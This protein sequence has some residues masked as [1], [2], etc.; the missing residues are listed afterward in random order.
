MAKSIHEI[1]ADEIL[2]NYSIEAI[3]IVFK[4]LAIILNENADQKGAQLDICPRCKGAGQYADYIGIRVCSLCDGTG[5][6]R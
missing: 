5:K 6:C 1:I 3:V 4:R 2:E